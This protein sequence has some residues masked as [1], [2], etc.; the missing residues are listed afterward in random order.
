MSK[1]GTDAGAAYMANEGIPSS[2]IVVP[3]VISIPIK[4]YSASLTLM[5]REKMVIQVLER[6]DKSAVA[7]IVEGK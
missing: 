7:T 2:V 4:H 1:G 5:L 6:F 3:D